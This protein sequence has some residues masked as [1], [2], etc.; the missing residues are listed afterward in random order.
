M[1]HH[2]LSCQDRNLG[3]IFLLLLVFHPLTT[4][5]SASL[6]GCTYKIY[7]ES[8]HLSSFPLH[9][10]EYTMPLCVLNLCILQY[11]IVSYVHL[12]IYFLCSP[13]DCQHQLCL[14]LVTIITL[15]PSAVCSVP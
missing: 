5:P 6:D 4:N 10:L 1:A 13:L 2:P 14:V 11:V 9:P 15:M 3:I 12:S 8:I 7:L